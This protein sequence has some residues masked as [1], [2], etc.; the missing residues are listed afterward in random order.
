MK[1]RP[2]ESADARRL[3]SLAI[4][5]DVGS[6]DITSRM[7]FKSVDRCRCVIAARDHGMLC[8]S[9]IARMAFKFVDPSVKVLLPTADGSHLESGQPVLTATGPATSILSA[10]RT[11]LNFLSKLSGIATL[12]H[13]FFHEIGDSGAKLYDTRKTT[14]GWR[15]LDKYAVRCGRGC[16]HRMGLYDAVLIKDNHLA[17]LSKKRD[18]SLLPVNI[19]AFRKINGRKF[20]VEIEVQDFTQLSEALECSPDIIMLDNFSP[21]MVKRAARKIRA[22]SSSIRIEI[23]GGINLGN[24][25]EY[26]ACGADIISVGAITHSAPALDFSLDI[27]RVV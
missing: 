14:P 21:A 19:A 25:S 13:H 6:G 11:A 5:E 20:P 22:R 17:I 15:S 10:E 7:L 18:M 1:L 4:R 12:T 16:N 8:G 26:A 9:E 27:E 23:S 24:I 2:N 3:V